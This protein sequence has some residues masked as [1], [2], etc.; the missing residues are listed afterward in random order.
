MA[1]ESNM[2]HQQ[3]IILSQIHGEGLSSGGDAELLRSHIQ[4]DATDVVFDFEGIDLISPSF[5]QELKAIDDN[6]RDKKFHFIG[7]NE[8]V[9]ATLARVYDWYNYEKWDISKTEGYKAAMDDVAN[10]RVHTYTSMKD[11]MD[12]LSK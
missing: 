3:T 1:A 10:G 7:M 4:S 8:S 5:A 12:D 2:E 6:M 9:G 11:L